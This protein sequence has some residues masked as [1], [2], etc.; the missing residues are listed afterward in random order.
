MLLVNALMKSYY[1][2]AVRTNDRSRHPEKKTELEYIMCVA[3]QRGI[4]LIV[5]GR[6][7][8][9]SNVHKS[10][11]IMDD[12]EPFAEYDPKLKRIRCM[13]M[14]HGKKK[15]PLERPPGT[16]GR[17][18]LEERKNPTMAAIPWET[19]LL[20]GIPYPRCPDCDHQMFRHGVK[21]CFLCLSTKPCPRYRR[22]EK[23]KKAAKLAEIEAISHGKSTV[24]NRI[25]GSEEQGMVLDRDAPERERNLP[26][27]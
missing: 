3:T 20:E 11:M 21:R 7:G 14:P 16:P 19:R 4:A 25:Q 10:D 27:E 15:V 26:V 23:E 12:W 18:T 2:I 9:V 13:A 5:N 1:G 6:T 22:M 24:H 17:K 8:F